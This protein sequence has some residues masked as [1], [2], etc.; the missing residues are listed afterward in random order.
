M[1][2]DIILLPASSFFRLAPFPLTCSR[3][4]PPSS[5][6]HQKVFAVS[7][8]P[9]SGGNVMIVDVILCPA[10]SFFHLAPFALTCSRLFPPSSSPHQK[11]FAVSPLPLSRGK[12]YDC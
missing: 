10:S 2:V 8:L 6:P 11:V 12:R 4:F 5:S 3:V 7:P 9:L 1:I